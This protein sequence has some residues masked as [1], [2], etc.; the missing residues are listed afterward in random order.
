M[1][2]NIIIIL[3]IILFSCNEREINNDTFQ[4]FEKTVA[5]SIRVIDKPLNVTI[6][7][8]T[9]P[10]D[11]ENTKMIKDQIEDYFGVLEEA[12]LE[13]LLKVEIESLKKDI[14]YSLPASQMVTNQDTTVTIRKCGTYDTADETIAKGFSSN[15]RMLIPRILNKINIIPINFFIIDKSNPD[16]EIQQSDLQEQLV[17]LNDAF[18]ELNI[19]FRIGEILN[20]TNDKWYL[21]LS[22]NKEED[23]VYNGYFEDMVNNLPLNGNQMN[24]IINGC[25]LLGQASLPFEEDTYRTKYDH[26]IINRYSL[27]G[28]KVPGSKTVME[29][30]TLIHEMGHYFGL[31]HTFHSTIDSGCAI[32]PFDGCSEGD[33][34]NDTPPQRFCHQYDCDNKDSCT[35]DSVKDDIKNYMGYNPDYCMSYFTNGQYIRMEKFFYEDRYYLVP[36]I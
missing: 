3:S 18:I 8:D 33:L 24:V 19:E 31:Y 11:I 10:I 12:K 29:G 20:Y 36:S 22:S 15:R 13:A 2:K 26:V 34:V 27:N 4:K 30:D 7:I 32:E 25:D 6:P 23:I 28:K 9:A 16:W 21:A 5:D 14:A 1:N 35:Y 17:I